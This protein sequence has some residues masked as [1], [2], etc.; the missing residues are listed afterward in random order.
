MMTQR[1]TAYI[2]ANGSPVYQIEQNSDENN[3][4][5][6]VGDVTDN[7]TGAEV[8]VNLFNARQIMNSLKERVEV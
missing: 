6:I 8:R 1:I 3:I 4:W 5:C 7:Y 2:G